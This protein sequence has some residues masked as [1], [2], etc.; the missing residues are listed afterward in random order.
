MLA[1]ELF[2]DLD[3]QQA[4]PL[5]ENVSLVWEVLPRIKGFITERIQP[6]VEGIR[7]HGEVLA[8]TH[9]L[10]QGRVFTEGL[11]MEPGEAAKG[12]FRVYHGGDLLEGATVI[13][14]GAALLDDRIEL[15]PGVVVEPGALIKG[16]T[17]IGEKSEV[18][19]GAYIRG[20]CLVG[21]RCVVGHVT[22]AKNTVMLDDAKAGHFAYLGDSVLGREVNLGAGTKLANLKIV[23]RPI[24]ITAGDTAFRVDFR[25]FGAIL[26]D[27]AETGCNSVTSPGAVMGKRCLVAPNMTVP[28]GYHPARTIIRPPK[29][30]P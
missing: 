25:K 1:P 24:T 27:A 28:P 26:G 22:E 10:W 12:E 29:A 8:R 21:R 9:A 13:Y 19:Q 2:F 6:N 30:K 18:R 4:A 20:S 16:P 5:F 7:V 23:S 14:A 15:G 3:G 17:I 11:R